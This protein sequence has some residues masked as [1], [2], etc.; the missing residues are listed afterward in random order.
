MKFIIYFLC[1]FFISNLIAEEK[2]L[3][4]PNL[5]KR[6]L[7]EKS[8][9]QM[10]SLNYEEK[11]KISGFKA[12]LYSVVVPG[13]GQYY[14]E[15][16]WR[17]ALYA[18]IEVAAWTVY[19]IYDAKG[20][21]K[22]KEMREYGDKHWS[23]RKYWSRIYDLSDERRGET[24]F[25][26]LPVYTLDSD[27]LIENYNSDVVNTLREYE[28]KLDYSHSLPSTHTQQYYEM[29]YKY[30]GQFANGWSDASFKFFY[31]ENGSDL[32]GTAVYFRDLR[33]LSDEYFDMATNA[34]M[35]ALINHVVS[36]LDAALAARSYNRSLQMR[37]SV[38]NKYLANEKVRMYGLQFIW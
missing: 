4:S 14:A 21:D 9:E 37:F 2:Y 31:A 18:T 26:N 29:I 28:N 38:K 24:E 17:A 16:Y 3:F 11:E 13:A 36:A 25:Q 10:D 12:A 1:L 6:E 27:N 35:G 7:I 8:F 20:E 19:F 22:D 32:P 23:E 15:S 5:Q 30:P 33:N 34:T